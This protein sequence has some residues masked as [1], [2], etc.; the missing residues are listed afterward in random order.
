MSMSVAKIELLREAAGLIFY[1]QETPENLEYIMLVTK[2]ATALEDLYISLLK[3][4]GDGQE[5][6]HM[7]AAHALAGL[8]CK[9]RS[10][11]HIGNNGGIELLHEMMKENLKILR[12]LDARFENG[13]ADR[14]DSEEFDEI[15][16][17]LRVCLLALLNLSV[18]EDF[19]VAIA[20]NFLKSLVEFAYDE[21]D[22]KLGAYASK[23][24]CN[25]EKSP[26]FFVQSL[27][28]KCQLQQ[29]SVSSSQRV[30]A[31]RDEV[32]NAEDFCVEFCRSKCSA[33]AIATLF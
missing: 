2:S 13:T 33:P 4:H 21:S 7:E 26:H 19:H 32:S 5:Y 6:L 10:R 14:L 9:S 24:I 27:I 20:H 12:K 30:R 15:Y 11:L 16:E 17:N 3:R 23:I 22:I 8:C 1:L 31:S 18:E 29:T 25:L 28:Y